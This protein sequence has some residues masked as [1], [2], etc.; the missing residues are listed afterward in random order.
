MVGADVDAYRQ[1]DALFLP[2]TQLFQRGLQHP[3][4]Q[5]DLKLGALE[6]RQE[7][8]RAEQTP[9]GVLP[10]NQCLEPDDLP[11]EQVHLGLVIKPKFAVGK[12]RSKAP[13]PGLPVLHGTI[14]ARVE[15]IVGVTPTPLGPIHGLVGMA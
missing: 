15:D 12:G 10:T 4:A 3:F 2:G 9:L 14:L 8:C 13:P 5:L 11:A 7:S 1:H 6:Y